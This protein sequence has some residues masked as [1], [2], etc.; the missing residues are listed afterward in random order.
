MQD[1]D[2]IR[3]ASAG[4]FHR[5]AQSCV[6]QSQLWNSFTRLKAKIMD[7]EITLLRR[8]PT[9]ALCRLLRHSLP[10]KNHNRHYRHKSNGPNAPV[11]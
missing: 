4:V 8:G 5:L 11:H 2:G 3:G 6:V 7:G 1:E 9:G 10:H